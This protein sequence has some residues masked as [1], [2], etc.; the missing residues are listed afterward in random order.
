M[1]H[2]TH[3]EGTDQSFVRRQ[4]QALAAALREA[5]P[6]APTL[7]EGW[8]AAD[9]AAHVW[10]HDNRLWQGIGLGVAP[11]AGYTKAAMQRVRQRPLDDVATEIAEGPASAVSPFRV[12]RLDTAMNSSEMFIHTEDIRRANGQTEPRVLDA[13]DA[14]VLWG[15]ARFIARMTL[16]KAPVGV[17][18]ARTGDR[19]VLVHK[20]AAGRGTVTLVGPAGELLLW[21]SGRREHAH[22]EMQ[23]SL[24]DIEQLRGFESHL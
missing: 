18:L 20:P 8:D 21:L 19:P 4:R 13:A 17:A 9:L 14:D 16:R 6:D 22:V 15:Q 11:L 7:C 3:L 12:A 24:D 1:T 23:G 10:Q 2:T 5:G